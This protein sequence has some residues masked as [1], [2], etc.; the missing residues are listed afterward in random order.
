MSVPAHKALGATCRPKKG[1]V[2]KVNF[3]MHCNLHHILP[4]VAD[5]YHK[6]LTAP[7]ADK[8]SAASAR[9]SSYDLLSKQILVLIF[10]CLLMSNL[11]W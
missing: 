1:F 7:K 5:I 11:S 10:V 2:D 8:E 4:S 6:A 3:W 9:K